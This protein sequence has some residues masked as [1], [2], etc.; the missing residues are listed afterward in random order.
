MVDSIH[1]G[2]QILE[3]NTKFPWTRCIT[4]PHSENYYNNDGSEKS[5]KYSPNTYKLYP[6]GMTGTYGRIYMALNSELE[7]TDEVIRENS[8]IIIRSFSSKAD[9]SED[10]DSE[11]DNDDDDGYYIN[12]YICIHCGKQGTDDPDCSHCGKKF[13]VMAKTVFISTYD[14]NE[15]TNVKADIK[16]KNEVSAPTST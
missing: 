16:K 6:T 10:D 11:D 12:R 4:W 9:E 1:T 14:D 3:L 5:I 15:E 7:I 8:L 13:C 2:E